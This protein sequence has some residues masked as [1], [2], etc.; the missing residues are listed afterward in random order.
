MMRKKS[1]IDA[2]M[3]RVRQRLLAA[4]LLQPERSWYLADLSR[5]LGLAPSSL[6]REL[7]ALGSAGILKT[8]RRGRMVFYRAD[9]DAPIFHEL[10]GLLRKTAGLVDAIREALSPWAGGIRWAFVFGSMASHEEAPG[11]DVDLFII[12]MVRLSEIAGPVRELSAT[13][14]REV[15]PKI[16]A[17]EEYERRLA[18]HDHF[19][20]S[21]MKK[22]K[23]F[24]FG[25][26]HNLGRAHRSKTGGRRTR[27]QAG[28]R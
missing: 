14:G 12:G 1:P 8:E 27:E 21:V 23:L 11:S 10:Q 3:P 19:V 15:N 7:A 13:L 4:T 18:A 2:L 17:A 22:A 28:N 16:F 24:V 9:Q 20:E 26:E 6:Q 25:S 5:Y